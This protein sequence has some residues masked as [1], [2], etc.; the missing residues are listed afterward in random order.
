MCRSYEGVVTCLTAAVATSLVILL[1]DVTSASSPH[2]DTY[3]PGGKKTLSLA[4]T[5][6]LA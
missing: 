1:S 2:K 4:L 6:I 5:A 3:Y